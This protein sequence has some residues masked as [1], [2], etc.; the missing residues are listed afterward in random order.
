MFWFDTSLRQNRG[1]RTSLAVTNKSTA[2]T[3]T[4]LPRPRLDYKDICENAAYKENNALNRRSPIPVGA[5]PSIARMYKEHKQLSSE[6]NSRIHARGLIGDKI[7]DMHGSDRDKVKQ[8]AKELKAQISELERKLVEIDEKLFSLALA[9]PND[10]HPDSPKGSEDAA[11]TVATYGPEPTSAN[12][13]RDHVA[14]GRALGLLDFEAAATVTG[15]SWY[16]LLNEGALLEFALTQYALNMALSRGFKATIVPDVIRSDVATRCGFQPRDQ[17][18][19][20]IHQMYHLQQAT[21]A[22]PELVLSGTAEIPLAGLF[23]NKI[24]EKSSLPFKHVGLGRAFRSEA[25]ARGAD[26]RGL[27][28][29]HQFT[30][31]ELFAV[32]AA[33]DSETMMNEMLD[34]QIEIFSK[35]GLTLRCVQMVALHYLSLIHHPVYLICLQRNWVPVHIGSMTLRRGCRVEEA[36]VKSPR[37]RTARTIS[38][39]DCTSA[40][41][42]PQAVMP[43]QIARK[44]LFDSHIRLTEPL[45]PSLV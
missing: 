3:S 1:L 2:K 20:P 27:Y 9:I 12:L 35:L 6:L 14:V 25:G 11:V 21:P 32:T 34:L 29:V 8:E 42:C 26:T 33:E 23:A 36:G 37:H 18:D 16:Y 30:K 24:F 17:G 19:A 38:R 41:G 44:I 15:S 5:V 7:R 22:Q 28:R 40:I 13:Q 10:T 45:L 4:G 43:T 39:G 31:L